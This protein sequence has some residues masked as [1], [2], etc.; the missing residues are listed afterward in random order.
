[1]KIQGHILLWKMPSIF[2]IHSNSQGLSNFTTYGGHYFGKNSRYLHIW[3]LS[4]IA[5]PT[6]YLSFIALCKLRGIDVSDFKFLRH[7][8]TAIPITKTNRRSHHHSDG[9]NESITKLI[10]LPVLRIY[11]LSHLRCL[12]LAVRQHVFLVRDGHSEALHL[13]A[14]CQIRK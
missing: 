8:V 14:F 1:M 9:Y 10:A 13:L 4:F 11:T 7:L 12:R 5:I 6:S 2:S 3:D